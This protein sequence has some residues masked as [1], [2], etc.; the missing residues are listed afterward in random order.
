MLLSQSWRTIAEECSTFKGSL[1][2][3]PGSLK[4]LNGLY[5]SNHQATNWRQI[6]GYHCGSSL[7]ERTN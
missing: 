4:L 5:D 7:N 6:N 1:Y 2:S 3:R